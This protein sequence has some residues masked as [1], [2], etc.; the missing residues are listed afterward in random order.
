M[1]RVTWLW[2]KTN[3]KGGWYP[4]GQLSEEKVLPM[5]NRDR[6]SDDEF[7]HHVFFVEAPDRRQSGQK[8][9]GRPQKIL[10]SMPVATNSHARCRTATRRSG[11]ISDLP[12]WEH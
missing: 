1:L 3:V 6:Q 4:T 5:E 10:A 7:S 8:R 11:T 9:V 12:P 2:V